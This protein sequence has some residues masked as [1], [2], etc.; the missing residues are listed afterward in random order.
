MPIDHAGSANF[1]SG[2]ATSESGVGP[3]VGE[4]VIPDPADLVELIFCPFERES[5]CLPEE[6]I[7]GAEQWCR[8]QLGESTGVFTVSQTA[9]LAADC[10]P[11]AG[12]QQ[13]ALAVD[14][15]QWGYALE[16]RVEASRSLDAPEDVAQLLRRLDGILRGNP[17]SR[18]SE[19]IEVSLH[20]VL[21]RYARFASREEVRTFAVGNRRRF[22]ALLWEAA[23]RSF[24]WLP[25]ELTYTNLAPNRSPLSVLTYA[26]GPM[27]LVRLSDRAMAD[28]RVRTCRW[29]A[30]RIGCW[31]GDLLTIDGQRARRGGHNLVWIRANRRGT[32]IAEAVHG[33]VEFCNREIEEFCARSA[34]LQT[35]HASQREIVTYAR[36]LSGAIV[37]A[38]QFGAEAGSGAPRA[39]ATIDAGQ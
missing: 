5:A 8:D 3:R 6:I 9:V 31:V 25:D 27:N 32:G 33:S 2:R 22:D 30:R 29:L 36:R 24:G 23:N 34:Q 28:V 18:D 37:G 21:K 10:C 4:E 39:A 7:D 15:L 20:D 13:L 38:I 12:P 14:Y 11:D 26:L 17:P 35:A 16:R 19:P 1:E